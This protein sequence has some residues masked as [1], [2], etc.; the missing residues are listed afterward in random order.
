MLPPCLVPS[1]SWLIS[2]LSRLSKARY[3]FSYRSDIAINLRNIL[4]EPT[5]QFGVDGS[6]TILTGIAFQVTG[7]KLSGS[8]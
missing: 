8:E 5:L 2:A 4:T 7:A 1:N 6:G 3:K